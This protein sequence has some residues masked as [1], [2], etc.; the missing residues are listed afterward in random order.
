MAQHPFRHLIFGPMND[1][2]V[3]LK[4]LTICQRG[5]AYATHCLK[6]PSDKF[7]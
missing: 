5:L 6:G 7:I 3:F 2:K 1:E 4:H